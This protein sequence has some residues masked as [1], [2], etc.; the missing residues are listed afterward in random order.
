MRYALWRREKHLQ[1]SLATDASSFRYGISLMS[2]KEKGLSFGDFWSNIDDRPIYLKEASAVIIV[3][4]ALE[5]KIKDRRLDVYVDNTAVLYAWENQRQLADLMKKLFQI[6]W[7]LNV[8]LK[9]HYVPSAENLA[10]AP[11]RNIRL[12][13]TTNNLASCR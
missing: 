9:L 7:K 13:V 2:G 11:S 8:D 5:A 3:L 4:Q 6:M 12:H 10:D 1:L